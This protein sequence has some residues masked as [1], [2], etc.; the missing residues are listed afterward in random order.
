MYII[1]DLATLDAQMNVSRRLIEFLLEINKCVL[2]RFLI[3][4]GAKELDETHICNHFWLLKDFYLANA[5]IILAP[6]IRRKLY[7]LTVKI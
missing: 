2:K 4:H 5:S 7:D 3:F 1:V 6:S